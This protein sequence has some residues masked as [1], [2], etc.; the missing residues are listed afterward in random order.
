MLLFFGGEIHN[1]VYKREITET[2]SSQVRKE[3]RQQDVRVLK[4]LAMCVLTTVIGVFPGEPSPPKLEGALQSKG[5]TLKVKWIKQDD[6]G[7]PIT[8]YLI[9]Y[10]AV[11]ITGL[12]EEEKKGVSVKYMMLI[13]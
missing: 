6:G 12:K 8:H 10:K 3:T 11:S 1:S 13:R 5:N 2:R 9:R 4:Y 7:S